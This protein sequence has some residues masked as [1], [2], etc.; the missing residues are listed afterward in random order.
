MKN[1]LTTGLLALAL[2]APQALTAQ[3]EEKAPESYIYATYFYCDVSRQEEA[4]ELVKANNKSIYDAAVADGTIAGWGWMAH[5]TGGKW[6][7]IQYHTGNSIEQLL[8]GQET[9]Q[10]RMEKAGVSN[11]GFSQI[12]GAHDDYIWKAEAGNSTQTD[13]GTAGLSVY[14][15]CDINKEDRALEIVKT[16]FAPVLDK[17]K[18][19]GKIKSW[20]YNSHVLG[21]KFRAL[22]TMTGSDFISLMKARAEILEA[23]YQDG[24]NAAAMEYSTICTS[25]DDYLWEILEE[26]N[27]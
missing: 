7:R 9:I 4:D 14:E 24:K 26:N 2:C 13:R 1:M 19:E 22:Q 8:K 18:A 17:A 15:V 23:I 12:C 25:H 21:G 10:E 3:E 6:R 27:G 20:G 11:D 16:V 5:H